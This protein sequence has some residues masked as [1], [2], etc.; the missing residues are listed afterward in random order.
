M[1]ITGDEVIFHTK[2]FGH[3][4]GMSQAG[5]NGMASDG[6]DYKTILSH[7][8]TGVSFGVIGQY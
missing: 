7:Y 8:Y 4:V 3:G 2:G 6:A 5:A 1:E